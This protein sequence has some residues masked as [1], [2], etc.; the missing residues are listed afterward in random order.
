MSRGRGRPVVQTVAS[1]PRSFDGIENLL[2]G[3]VIVAQSRWTEGQILAAYERAQRPPPDLHVIPP[4]VPGPMLRSEA[5]ARA[6][7]RALR[8]PEGAPL[9][10]YPGDVEVSRGA[11]VTSEIAQRLAHEVPGAVTV[12]AYRNKSAE[13]APAAE[14]LR[15]RLTGLEV[16]FAATLPDILALIASATAVVFPVDDLWGKVDLPI[17]LL[18]AMALDVP[19]VAYDHGPLAELDGAELLP[20]LDPDEWVRALKP[21][22]DFPAAREERAERQRRGA[23]AASLAPRVARAYEELYL[24]LGAERARAPRGRPKVRHSVHAGGD[25]S[26]DSAA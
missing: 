24:A 8:I 18:E 15:Q 25:R 13:A 4:P 17:V 6:A 16:R 22:V 14:R 7:R 2:F 10:V 20:S 19:V 5:E 21:L 1:A 26:S 11:Q 3:D 23:F 9:F 12:F